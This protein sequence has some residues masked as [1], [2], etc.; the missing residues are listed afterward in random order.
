MSPYAKAALSV[1]RLIAFGC[2]ILSLALYS[3][4]YFLFLSHRPLPGPWMLAL[5]GVPFLAGLILYWKARPWALRLTRD[6]E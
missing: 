4:D 6:L 5:K 1:L 3:T 2:I